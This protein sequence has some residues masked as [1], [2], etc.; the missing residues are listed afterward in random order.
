VATGGGANV[1]IS[2]SYDVLVI[3]GG[4]GGATTA[5]LVAAEGRSVL[6]VE[7]RSPEDFKIGESLMPETWQTFERLGVLDRLEASDFPRKYS[8]QFFSKTGAASAPFY[9]FEEDPHPK[10][11]TWQ[12]LRSDFDRLLVERAEANGCEVLWRSRVRDVIFDGDRAVGA[13]LALADGGRRRIDCKV[14]VDGSGQSALLARRL[15]MRRIDPHLRHAAIY[16][17]F[18]GAYRDEGIDEGATL[19]LHSEDARSW[20]WYIPMPGNRV[21]VGV[22]GGVDYLVGSRD[23]SPQEIFEEEVARCP[24]IRR[25]IEGACQAMPVSVLRDFSSSS[26]EIAGPGWVLVGDAYSFIDPVY[27]SGILL[28][29]KSG[30]MAAET[31]LEAL[32]T[33]DLSGERLGSFRPALDRGMASLRRL[34]YAFYSEDFNFGTFLRRY[35]EHRG[36]IVDILVGRVFDRDFSLLFSRMGEMFDVPGL[37]AESAASPATA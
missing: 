28:A 9:F 4:P 13:D 35:P 5:A 3:G 32:S 11:V 1:T 23:G 36:E 22:V 8:V 20:F 37:G 2:D 10:A 25:R 24:E 7:A 14:V 31:I 26:A 33:G 19:I 16:S 17:H 27:S 30:E 18:E 34:V 29:L 15:G 12:V 21:S 6:L